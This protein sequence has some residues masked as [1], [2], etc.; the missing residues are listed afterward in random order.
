MYS[1]KGTAV[2]FSNRPKE[3]LPI[4]VKA[5]SLVKDS[6]TLYNLTCAQSVL[7]KLPQAEATF[8]EALESASLDGRFGDAAYW[9]DQSK[10]DEQLAALRA[11]PAYGR[12]VKKF[13][14]K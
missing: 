3:A 2:L 10:S 1:F 13:S 8:Q 7:G 11:R 4:L 12:A 6:R 9:I 14:A 5:A